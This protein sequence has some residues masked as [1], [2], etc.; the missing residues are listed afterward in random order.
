MTTIL[1]A[2]IEKIGDEIGRDLAQWHRQNVALW[3]D[4]EAAEHVAKMLETSEHHLCEELSREIA[5]RIIERV[6][7][8][9]DMELSSDPPRAN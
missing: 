4:L 3:S 8:I 2:I 6:R 1:D 7:M 9:Y 5:T